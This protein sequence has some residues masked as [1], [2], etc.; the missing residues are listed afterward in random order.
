MKM[1]LK[2]WSNEFEKGAYSLLVTFNP[3]TRKVI[4][5]FI[6]TGDST[7]STK[8]YSDLLALCKVTNANPNYYISP[9]NS[10]KDNT[11]YTGIRIIQK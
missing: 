2:E 4:D 11:R 8:N 10:L 6:G 7:G 9:V 1:K 5:Y 3:K